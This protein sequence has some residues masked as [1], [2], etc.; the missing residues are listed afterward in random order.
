LKTDF[1]IITEQLSYNNNRSQSFYYVHPGNNK[2]IFREK[3][4]TV[5]GLPTN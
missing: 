2:Q 3:T 1:Q 5:V 4:V